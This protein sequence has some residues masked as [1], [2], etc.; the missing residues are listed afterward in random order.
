ML[1][2]GGSA[3][4]AGGG[5][6][7]GAVAGALNAQ[8]G[9][10][11][12]GIS[13]AAGDL[14]MAGADDDGGGPAEGA[15][16]V[17]VEVISGGKVAAVTNCVEGPGTATVV[18]YPDGVRGAH[19]NCQPA[20]GGDGSFLINEV[21]LAFF[22]TSVGQ[23]DAS[24]FAFTCDS[25]EDHCAGESV[26]ATYE[27]ADGRFAYIDTSSADT[28][29]GTFTLDEFTASGRVSGSVD[30]T[31]SSGDYALTVRGHFAS[32]LIDCGPAATA[33]TAGDGTCLGRRD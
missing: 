32:H 17:S 26:S 15:S 33:A 12:G 21:S 6:V 19:I 11:G 27:V 14:G 13:G 9:S 20:G 8:G 18:E 16:D 7:A 22:S 4:S 1:G 23:H 29:S 25:A 30:V 31:M 24:E 28:K 2:Q 10:S 5:G 3:G